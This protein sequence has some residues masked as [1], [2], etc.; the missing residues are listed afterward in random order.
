MNR[1]PDEWEWVE[2]YIDM[3]VRW[4]RKPG[5]RLG[6]PH[7]IAGIFTGCTTKHIEDW[8]EE[9]D[10]RAITIVNR[11]WKDLPPTEGAALL[12]TTGLAT[13]FRFREPVEAV[14]E[15]ARAKIAAALRKEGFQ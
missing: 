12:H 2:Y 10:R 15:R 14:F 9:V 11:V 6:L 1:T 13:V 3:W 5:M 4:M 7:R 8:E